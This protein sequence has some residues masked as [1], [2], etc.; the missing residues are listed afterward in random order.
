MV[1]PKARST[2][3]IVI[4]HSGYYCLRKY[5]FV[6]FPF[7]LSHKEL[8]RVAQVCRHFHRLASD[9]SLGKQVQITDCCVL[10]DDGLVAL[11]CRQPRSLTLHRCRHASR[12][13]DGPGPE[14]TFPALRG[15]S[16]VSTKKKYLA[17]LLLPPGVWAS[18]PCNVHNFGP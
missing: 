13:C 6:Y 1:F 18:W 3:E 10:E 15:C 8:A 2:K 4:S 9:E 7:C 14:T 12:G 11:A 16:S 5:G 17:A